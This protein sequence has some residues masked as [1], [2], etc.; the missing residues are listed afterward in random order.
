MQVMKY[1]SKGIHSGFETQDRHHQKS[2]AGVS[3]APQ[4]GLMSSIFLKIKLCNVCATEKKLSQAHLQHLSLCCVQSDVLQLLVRHKESCVASI[5]RATHRRNGIQ[6]RSGLYRVSSNRSA[7]SIQC[8]LL[9]LDKCLGFFLNLR[10]SQE[11]NR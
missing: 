4:K 5:L 1:T 9:F 8:Q 10:R 11:L 7:S 6:P 2:K 3:V